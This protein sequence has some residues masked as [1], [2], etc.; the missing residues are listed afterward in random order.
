MAFGK[1]H[2][3]KMGKKAALFLTGILFRLFSL[4]IA[5]LA[6]IGWLEG[7]IPSHD[8]WFVSFIGLGLMPLL[9]LNFIVFMFW[10]FKRN[11][12][13]LVSLGAV[14]L[15]INYLSAMIQFDFRSENKLPSKDIKIASYNI[16]GSNTDAFNLDL[17]KVMK[18]FNSQDVDVICFQEFSDNE[19]ARTDSIFTVYPYNIIYSQNK[20]MQLAVFSKYPLGDSEFMDFDNTANNSMWVDVDFEACPFRIVNVH[21]QTTNVNQSKAEITKIRD[22]GIKDPDGKEAFDIVMQRI[23]SNATQRVE[24]AKTVRQRI[25]LTLPQKPLILCGD[26]NDTP[27]SYTYN[28]ISRKL[29][30]GFKTS[31]SGYGYTYKSLYNIFRIDYIFYTPNFTGIKYTSPNVD[32]SDHNP[33]LLE[34]SI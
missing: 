4:I 26:F 8:Y 1:K 17:K 16:H 32:W 22:L 18:Y 27:A 10:A 11:W 14:L 5:I 29:K 30:D 23:T 25:D 6:V 2:R 7:F 9:V 21:F 28:N 33:V 15:N 12:W 13:S 24:Q 34:L 19:S 3:E 31:G 20:G